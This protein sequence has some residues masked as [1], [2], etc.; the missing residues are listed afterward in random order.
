MTASA[1]LHN[2]KLSYLLKQSAGPYT[3]LAPVDSAFDEYKGQVTADILKY[4][5]IQGK[6]TT[7]SLS[8]GG[9]STLQGGSLTYRRMFRKDFLDE[10]LVGV[11]SA[12]ASKGGNFPCDVNA[13]N[14]VVHS[15]NLILVPGAF[16]G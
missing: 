13:D 2:V 1:G 12:G 14:G 7:D 15:I 11:K 8:S 16:Q 5:I 6:R 10:A 4:H 9:L 3:V